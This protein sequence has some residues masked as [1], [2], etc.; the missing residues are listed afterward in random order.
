MKTK[1]ING[2]DVIVA[3]NTLERDILT[4]L[5]VHMTPD[6]CSGYWDVKNVPS[7]PLVPDDMNGRFYVSW[8]DQTK[9]RRMDPFSIQLSERGLHVVKM[10]K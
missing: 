1:Q 6:I 4:R 2:I 8:E 9:S 10:P 7:D 5:M 3:E